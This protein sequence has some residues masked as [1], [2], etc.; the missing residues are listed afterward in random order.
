MIIGFQLR[1]GRI[2]DRASPSRRKDRE[3]LR[4]KLDQESRTAPLPIN[5]PAARTESEATVVHHQGRRKYRETP[6]GNARKKKA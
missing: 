3:L 1:R 2:S 6:L 4:L 5:Q